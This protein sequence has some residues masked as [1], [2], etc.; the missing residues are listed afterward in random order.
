[1]EVLQG[2]KRGFEVP[3]G[4]WLSGPLRPLVHDLLGRPNAF[5]RDWVDGA[6]IDRLLSV[7]FLKTC[8]RDALVYALLVLEIWIEQQSGSG[9]AL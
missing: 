7:P 5:V 3:L 1:M 8:N 4:R 9:T 6:Y 2:P